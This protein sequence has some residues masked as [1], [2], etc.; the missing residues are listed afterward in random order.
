[1]SQEYSG[2]DSDQFECKALGSMQE[3]QVGNPSRG[4][5]RNPLMP[6]ASNE[7]GVE[8]LE[9]GLVSEYYSLEFSDLR[10]ESHAMTTCSTL[11]RAKS[12]LKLES[13][14]RISLE[15]IQSVIRCW[16][17]LPPTEA[18]S[19]NEQASDGQVSG[20]VWLHANFPSG[21]LGWNI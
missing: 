20:L 19:P 11:K 15:A 3:L 14:W 13:G 7:S 5:A 16:E 6:G 12:P 18:K 1:M 2:A 21:P 17:R 10:V 4:D 8:G 9:T